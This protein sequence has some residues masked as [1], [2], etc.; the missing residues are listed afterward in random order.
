MAL[1]DLMVKR[2]SP[3]E[4]RYEVSDRKGLS[5]RVAPSGKKTW[6]YRYLFDGVPRRMSLGVYPGVGLALAREKHSKAVQDVARA[7]DPGRKQAEAK[8][9]RRADPTFSDLIEEFWDLELTHKKAGAATRRLIEND[10]KHAWGN[11][12]VSD[13]KRRDIVLLLDKVRGRAPVGANRLHGALSRL[14]N[15]AAER[16]IVE[17]SPCVRIRKTPEKGRNRVLDN[18]ELKVFWSALALENKDVDMYWQTKLALKMILLT[19]QRPGEVCGMEFSEINEEEALWHIPPERSKNGEEHKVP[20]VPLALDV[21]KKARIL[22]GDQR[23]VFTSS[24]KTDS[25]VTVRSLAR[26]LGRHWSEIKIEEKFTPHD[27]RR[28]LRTRL[29]ELGVSDIVAE[30]VL[31]HKLQGLLAVYNHHQYSVEMRDA[32][33]KWDRKLRLITGMAKP[34]ANHCKVIQLRG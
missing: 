8:A 30:R 17:D 13:I 31:G 34:E 33:Q 14:F 4:K 27:L 10:T 6:V 21:I 19:G 1:T 9:R 26:A 16:G 7:I 18:N 12:K 5:L 28:T 29:A 23:F 32:L 3:H 15:F 25:S 24:H 2:F 22:S 11:R 20:L